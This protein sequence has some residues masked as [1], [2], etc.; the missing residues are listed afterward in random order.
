MKWTFVFV[1]LLLSGCNL[2]HAADRLTG[3]YLEDS[4][5]IVLD[6][7]KD[8]EHIRQDLQDPENAQ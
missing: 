5:Q 3:G 1:L 2:F 4:G 7:T 6:A 8:A